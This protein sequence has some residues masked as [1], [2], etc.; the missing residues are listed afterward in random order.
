[1][2]K[3][4][5]LIDMSFPTV[6]KQITQLFDVPDDIRFY[7]LIHFHM[8]FVK[9]ERESVRIDSIKFCPSDSSYA[10][11]VKNKKL[12]DLM[13]DPMME[14]DT[15]ILDGR[16]E[17][18]VEMLDEQ[19][20]YRNISFDNAVVSVLEKGLLVGDMCAFHWLYTKRL[21][22]ESTSPLFIER[23]LV[24]MRVFS[25]YELYKNQVIS[26]IE[27]LLEKEMITTLREVLILHRV[28]RGAK[29]Y[30]NDFMAKEQD[31]IKT[32]GIELF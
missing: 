5:L 11:C 29:L 6:W 2:N 14:L 23:I 28:K 26:L 9:A 27:Y 1:M 12:R 4:L 25:K 13:V 31:K 10:L 20:C 24:K 21:I 3:N 17:K 18:Y 32:L 30:L 15:R 8:P 7:V 19:L 16:I 22:D